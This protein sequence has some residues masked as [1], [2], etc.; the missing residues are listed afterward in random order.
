MHG[1]PIHGRATPLSEGGRSLS[2]FLLL[3]FVEFHGG[4]HQSGLSFS[5]ASKAFPPRKVARKRNPP[6]GERNSTIPEEAERRRGLHRRPG[7]AG[8]VTFCG[9]AFRG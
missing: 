6:R 2:P 1:P 3:A 7:A 5:V 8:A 4:G 9:S